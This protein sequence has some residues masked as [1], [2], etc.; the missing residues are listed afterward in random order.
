MVNSLLKSLKVQVTFLVVVFHTMGCNDIRTVNNGMNRR[1]VK[2]GKK[3]LEVMGEWD[4]KFLEGKGGN[5]KILKKSNVFGALRSVP[6]Q[7]EDSSCSINSLARSFYLMGGKLVKYNNCK[8]DKDCY[9]EF[10]Q[11]S[12][13][14]CAPMKEFNKNKNSLHKEISKSRSKYTFIFHEHEIIKN[15]HGTYNNKDRKDI[16]SKSRQKNS[17]EAYSFK[18]VGEYASMY[19]SKGVCGVKGYAKNYVYN[20]FE[21]CT[22]AIRIDVLSGKPVIG[23]FNAKENNS[24]KWVGHAMNIIGFSTKG[25]EFLVLNTWPYGNKNSHIG[26]Y[27]YSGMEACM[28]WNNSYEIL[29]FFIKR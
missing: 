8:D 10:L 29:R 5:F 21:A 9:E 24:D 15:K 23:S 18:L 1:N 26:K 17:P 3:C 28:R 25:R 20:S 14:F 6:V 4:G 2:G 22:K 19:L 13:S 16:F 7:Y 27:S 12:Y 11:N